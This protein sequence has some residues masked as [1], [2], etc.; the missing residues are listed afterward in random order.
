MAIPMAL[1]GTSTTD[2][3]LRIVS[4]WLPLA[5]LP[6]AVALL[7]AAWPPWVLMWSLAVSI[8]AGFKWLTF[9]ICAEARRA[10]TT[11]KIGYL[12]LW[13]GMDAKA[14]FAPNGN[15]PHPAA[16]E[17]LW[18]ILKTLFGLFILF[19]VTPLA[20]VY[21]QLLA[22][23]AGMIGIIFVLHFGLFH[24]LSVVWRHA[25]VAAEPIMNSPIMASSLTDFWGRRWNLAFR[26]LAHDYVFRPL[27]RRWGIAGA[28]LIVFVA[29]GIVHDVVMSIPA[30]DG[31]GLPTLYFCIQ[32][33]GLLV[34][35]S[36]LGKR[37]G[38][39]HGF[40]G[41][42]FCALVTVALLG[43]LFHRPFVRQVIIP[44]LTAIGAL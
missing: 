37:I 17:W 27:G 23:W 34:E 24:L 43:A 7:G 33:L 1:A 31:L 15:V 12:L 2:T 39:G 41:R 32:G 35:R 6:V 26:D 5:V 21:G 8:Y 11:R 3:R 28:T 30:G 10:S 29:S 13:P 22:G 40:V 25:G 18:S 20:D 16:N 36:E 38:L 19:A 9:A 14:F 4:P 44:T 42:L